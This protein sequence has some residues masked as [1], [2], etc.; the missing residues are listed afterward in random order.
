MA[1]KLLARRRRDLTSGEFKKPFSDF[2]VR[3]TFACIELGFSLGDRSGFL[4]GT[5]LLEDRFQLG[6]AALRFVCRMISE[7]A[8]NSERCDVSHRSLALHRTHALRRRSFDMVIVPEAANMPPT[9]WQT[10]ILE[11]G[12]WFQNIGPVQMPFNIWP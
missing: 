2:L 9:P 11:S 8:W 3:Y 1:T 12:I 7:F 5:D 10:E 6:H 4:V